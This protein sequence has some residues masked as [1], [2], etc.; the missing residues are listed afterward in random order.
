[1]YRKQLRLF[2]WGYMI[3]GNETETANMTGLGKQAQAQANVDIN[4]P[5]PRHTLKYTKMYLW[6]NILS[7]TQATFEAVFMKK[8]SNN[9][10]KLKKVLFVK[11]GV[12]VKQKFFSLSTAA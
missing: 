9:E 7:N 12:F 8:L 11:K 5:R 1:M 2:K 6:L 10:A 3:N 4:R